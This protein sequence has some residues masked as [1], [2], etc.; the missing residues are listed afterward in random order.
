[1]ITT[2]VSFT[3]FK[4]AV[5]DVLRKSLTRDVPA[6]QLADMIAVH[7]STVLSTEEDRK[8]YERLMYWIAQPD[9]DDTHAVCADVE[10]V[11][12]GV[13]TPRQARESK[14]TWTEISV[15]Q[16]FARSGCYCRIARE[17]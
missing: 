16:G 4:G 8:H 17:F 10:L 6:R 7:C 3:S 15:V 11:R 9:I 1:M 12:F 13:L 2:P 5:R 14:K